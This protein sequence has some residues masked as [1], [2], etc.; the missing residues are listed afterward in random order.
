MKNLFECE[1]CGKIFDK[2]E[3]CL[4]HELSDFNLEEKFK[5]NLLEALEGLDCV[6]NCKSEVVSIKANAY[7]DFY[8]QA[9]L[10]IT[11]IIK[12]TGLKELLEIKK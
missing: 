10:E 12:S 5:E 9:K 8:N 6:Y 7:C 3:E 11:C 4:K 2:K 1:V